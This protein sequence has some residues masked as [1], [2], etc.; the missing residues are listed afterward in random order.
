MARKMKTWMVTTQRPML[1]MRLRMWLPSIRSLRLLRWRRQRMNGRRMEEPTCS[2]RRFRLLRCS[3]RQARLVPYT[4]P[5][6][7]GALNHHLYGFP[8]SSADDPRTCIRS[9]ASSFRAYSTYL[10]VL[11]RPTLFRSL[12]TIPI[13]TRAVRLAARCSASPAFRK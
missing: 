5:W 1:P 12:A 7:A 4:V 2:D 3:P 8:G 13:F 6:L 10:P 9:P 11:W